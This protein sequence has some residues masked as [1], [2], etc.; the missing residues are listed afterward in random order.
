MRPVPAPTPAKIEQDRSITVKTSGGWAFQSQYLN[1]TDNAFA[2]AI[3]TL[4]SREKTWGEKSP[5]LTDWVKA[6]NV[7]FSNCTAKDQA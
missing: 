6:Q 1:C 3:S 4:H 5:E 2:T 7:V